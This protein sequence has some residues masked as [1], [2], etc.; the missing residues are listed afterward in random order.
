MQNEYEDDPLTP[1][2]PSAR[3]NETGRRWR[4]MLA[5]SAAAS[6]VG[7]GVVVAALGLS[8]GQ[9]ANSPEAMATTVRATPTQMRPQ[10][11]AQAPMTPGQTECDP[12]IL[13]RACSPS[14]PPTGSGADGA[15]AVAWFNKAKGPF[16][17]VQQAIQT[18]G[19]ALQAQDMD[20][21][22][23]ACQEVLTNSQRLGR[24]LPSPDAGI[25]TEVQGAVDELT[26]AA[27]LCLGADMTSN[28]ETIMS[29]VQN[30]NA[31]FSAAQQIIESK[32]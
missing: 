26:T 15:S 7:S 20:G 11:T 13:R 21:V 16:T 5:G 1:N 6:V 32:S 18:A 8:A 25:T 19:N 24:T 31:H 30:A 17:A 4:R 14:R 12:S 23:S 3:A 9:L 29:H 22:R 10:Y 27:N 2:P 28:A